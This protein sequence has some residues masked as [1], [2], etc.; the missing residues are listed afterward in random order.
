MAKAC[1]GRTWP[2]KA[3]D[4]FSRNCLISSR[5]SPWPAKAASRS[6]TFSA[7]PFLPELRLRGHF[8]PH[9]VLGLRMTVILCL[10]RLGGFRAGLV[11]GYSHSCGS[12]TRFF[13]L[14]R[15]LYRRSSG[16]RTKQ[17]SGERLI[18]RIYGGRSKSAYCRKIELQ[19][20]GRCWCEPDTERPFDNRS[21]APCQGLVHTRRT[22]ARENGLQ[23][24]SVANEG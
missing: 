3:A 15:A 19:V 21:K 5:P 20:A 7:Q 24:V 12:W 22:A 16:Q 14:E 10:L 23:K 1:L 2:S 13:A 11:R 8:G 17:N 6:S 9:E 4:P 18:R